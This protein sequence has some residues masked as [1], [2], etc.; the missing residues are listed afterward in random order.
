M[1][2]IEVINDPSMSEFG[3]I[4]GLVKHK[5][6]EAYYDELPAKI[7]SNVLLQSF[8]PQKKLLE[9][10]KV[11]LFVT[12]CGANS[13]SES[14]YFGTPMLAIPLD[15]DQFSNAKRIQFYNYGVYPNH[16][17]TKSDLLQEFQK[18]LDSSKD[19][20]YQSTVNK[21]RVITEF[22][23]LESGTTVANKV[24]YAAKFGAKHLY[25]QS[26]ADKATM[27]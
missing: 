27:W 11:K 20:I 7:S 13:F 22:E 2:L 17:E 25:H 15:V 18:V 10:P 14:V 16:I 24:R 12:H 19:N 21:M 8:V 23:E 6:T 3:F 9:H 1:T 5:K 4:I 26:S